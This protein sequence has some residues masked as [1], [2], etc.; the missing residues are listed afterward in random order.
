[1]GLLVSKIIQACSKHVFFCAI[2]L[3]TACTTQSAEYDIS[4]GIDNTK[5]IPLPLPSYQWRLLSDSQTVKGV[6]L[7]IHGLNQKPEVM[8]GIIEQLNRAGIETLNLT[9]FGHETYLDEELRLI[10]FKRASYKQWSNEIY[11][12]FKAAEKRALENK[13]PLFFVGNSIGGLL[14]CDLV[15][16]NDDVNFDRMVLF[17]PALSIHYTSRLL[18][19]FSPFSQLVIPSLTPE[20]Y[21]ANEGTP[22]AAYNALYEAIDHFEDKLSHKLNIPTL[23][24]IDESDELVS[25]SGLVE[26]IN[27]Q[28]LSNWNIEQVKKSENAQTNYKHLIVD[29]ASMGDQQWKRMVNSMVSHF[30]SPYLIKQ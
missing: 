24:F 23:L 14:A 1:M 12:A 9:L 21:R 26:L 5:S 7:V 15:V 10:N 2:V 30:T 17:A 11:Q 8:Q 25:Y 4:S 6:A 27:T 16:S 19:I 22:I 20:S 28:S 29:S 18:A 13:T 3:V